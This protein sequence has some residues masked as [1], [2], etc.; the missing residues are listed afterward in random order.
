MPVILAREDISAWLDA[1]TPAD[2]L[3]ALLRPCPEAWLRLDPVDPRVGNV[4][5][6]DAGLLEPLS[7]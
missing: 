2:R 1:A 5:N 4:R 7:V 3:L 6:D